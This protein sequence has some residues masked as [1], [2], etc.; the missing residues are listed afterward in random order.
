MP[1]PLTDLFISEFTGTALLVLLGTGVVANISLA[2]S[3]GFEGGWLLVTFGWGLGVFAGVYA[4]AASGAH[5][6]PAVTLGLWVADQDFAPDTPPSVSRFA[7]YL[8]AQLLGAVLGA[9]LTY[10]TYKKHFDAEKDEATRLGVFATGPAIRT[11]GWN[12]VTEAIATFVLVYVV[13]S[14]GHTPSGL[15]PLAVALLV[16][17]IGASLGGPTGYALNPARDAGPRLFHTLALGRG[18]ASSDWSYAWVPIVGP[19]AGG[20]LAALAYHLTDGVFPAV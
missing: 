18:G 9:L 10:L 6:N 20:V 19:M 4:A 11:P 1:V 17:G 5:L 3:K 2:R 15:G 8:L 13:L 12:A 16:V 7:I 14:F